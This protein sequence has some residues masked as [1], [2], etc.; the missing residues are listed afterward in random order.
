MMPKVT[1]MFSRS[2]RSGAAQAAVPLLAREGVELT[3]ADETETRDWDAFAREVERSDVLFLDMTRG[4][5]GFDALLDAATVVPLV[6]PG[7]RATRAEWPEI[8][9]PALTRVRRSLLG[10]DAEEVAEGVLWL[11]KRAGRGRA[12]QRSAATGE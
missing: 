3:V 6:V 12:V 1:Y 11:L 7:G 4:F 8:D 9:R 5:A 10:A 2:F